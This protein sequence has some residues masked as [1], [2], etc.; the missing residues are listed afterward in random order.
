MK[1]GGGGG[2]GGASIAQSK[3]GTTDSYGGSLEES[4]MSISVLG[5]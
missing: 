2:G 3:T 4:S 1:R 5:K